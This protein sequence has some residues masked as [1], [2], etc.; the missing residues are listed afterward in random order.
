MRI[1]TPLIRLGTRLAFYPGL[2]F[3]RAMAALGVWRHWDRVDEHLLVGAFPSPAELRKLR[4]LGVRAIVNLCEEHPGFSKELKVLGMSQLH[5]PTLDFHAPSPEALQR[6]VEFIC[7]RAAVG[8]PVY[9]HCK[10]GRK[11]SPLVAI[12][13]L[14]RVQG[15]TAEAAYESVRRARRHIDR[16]LARQRVLRA[17]APHAGA[18]AEFPET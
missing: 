7:D 18:P 2:W 13:Y 11:R 4:G 15:L 10:A 6:A 3:S 16:R 8:E 1:R 17:Y 14:M 5:V 9:V 12:A